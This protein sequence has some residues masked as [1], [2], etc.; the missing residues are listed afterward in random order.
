MVEEDGTRFKS[1]ESSGDKL[2]K[3]MS[4]AST[5][6]HSGMPSTE[7]KRG[8]NSSVNLINAPK[9][10]NQA[11]QSRVARASLLST[12][13]ASLDKIR[14]ISKGNRPQFTASIA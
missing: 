11:S 9:L 6:R 10:Q 4:I 1:I 14:D 12:R 8:S 13:I 2:N 3:H 5:Y 7:R